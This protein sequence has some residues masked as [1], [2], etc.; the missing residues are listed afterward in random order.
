MGITLVL[1]HG[2]ANVEKTGVPVVGNVVQIWLT[3]Y[4]VVNLH[5]TTTN[6]PGKKTPAR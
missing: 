1:G 6:T 5:E 2:A 3:Q 4:F